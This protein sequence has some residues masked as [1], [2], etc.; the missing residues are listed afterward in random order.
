[1]RRLRVL[2]KVLIIQH[3]INIHIKHDVMMK[4]NIILQYTFVDE[5]K[6]T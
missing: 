1:M 5:F 4:I 3:S 2:I 6:I